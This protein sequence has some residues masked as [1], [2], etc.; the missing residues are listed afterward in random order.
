MNGMIYQNLIIADDLVE[1]PSEILPFRT[2]TMISHVSMDLNILLHTTQDMKDLY[3]HWMKPK[4]LMDYIDYILNEQEWEDGIRID[5]VGIYPNTIV[6]K[7]IRL[8]N[9]VSL[10]GR[11]K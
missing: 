8:E 10:L 9:Q 4:G 1:P 6:V 2:I 5:V 7:S 3:Y 11:I